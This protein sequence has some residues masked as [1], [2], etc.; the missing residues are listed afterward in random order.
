MKKLTYSKLNTIFYKYEKEL[1][2]EAHLD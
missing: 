1:E 2:D